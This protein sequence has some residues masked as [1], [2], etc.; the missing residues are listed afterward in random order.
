MATAAEPTRLL[1]VDEAAER[2]NVSV[3]TLR[4]RIHDGEIPAVRLGP[5]DRHPLR[6][7]PAELERWL[8]PARGDEAA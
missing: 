6:V 4:R 8:R 7:D 1:R 2:L 3:T 5:T